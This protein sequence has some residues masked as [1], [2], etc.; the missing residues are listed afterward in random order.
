MKHPVCRYCSLLVL[1]SL[2]CLFSACKNTS[3]PES[4]IAMA[5]V[6]ALQAE[7]VNWLKGKKIVM[8]NIIQHG[9]MSGVIYLFSY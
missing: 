4:S 7:D 8:D 3:K 6:E 9:D 5:N 1:S 2:L